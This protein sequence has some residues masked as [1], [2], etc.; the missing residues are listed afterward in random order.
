MRFSEETHITCP[1]CGVEASGLDGID[2]IFGYIL[3]KDVITP[4]SECRECRDKKH[5]MKGRMK[6]N[7][8][9]APLWA[10]AAE[11]GKR[12][13]ISRKVFD[14]YL[15]EL[16]YLKAD[17]KDARK[18]NEDMV[19]DKGQ[20]HYFVTYSPLR[21]SFLWDYATYLEVVKMRVSRAV[22]RDICPKCRT[23]LEPVPGS[24]PSDYSYMCK[25][26]GIVCTHWNV[27][28]VYDR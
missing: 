15:I 11:W 27:D 24:K 14:S 3:V 7:N 21:E 9:K 5:P 16:G 18:V 1:T 22:V 12:I 17:Y 20:E 23:Q 13:H 19:T 2:K 4:C 25:R 10:T 8:Y 26:C 28:V 6:K